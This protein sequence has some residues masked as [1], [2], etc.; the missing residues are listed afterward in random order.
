MNVGERQRDF[1]EILHGRA[2]RTRGGGAAAI[3]AESQ[4][5]RLFAVYNSEWLMCS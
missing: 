3:K 1:S 2:S 4:A 5:E